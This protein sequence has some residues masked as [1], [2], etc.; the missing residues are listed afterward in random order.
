MEFE[1]LVRCRTKDN[2][3]V[4]VNYRITQYSPILKEL[5]ENNPDQEVPVDA[6]RAILQKIIGYFEL[7]AWNQPKANF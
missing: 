4:E 5:Y 6:T 1:Q 2:S 3:L 7:H